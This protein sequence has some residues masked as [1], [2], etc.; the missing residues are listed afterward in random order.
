MSRT[1]NG[2]VQ[3][4]SAKTPRRSRPKL[5][6]ETLGNY[7]YELIRKQYQT[8]TKQEKRVLADRDPEGLH[9]MRVASRRL[10]T[11]LQVFERAIDLPKAA[12]SNR[13]QAIAK[14]LGNLR[15][16]DVQ[17]A[18]LNNEYLPLLPAAEQRSLEEVVQALQQER[19]K[20]FAATADILG[21]SRYRDLKDAYDTWLHQPR[22]TAL[23]NLP[24]MLV[25]PDLLNP[26]LSDLLLHPAWLIPLNQAAELSE[27]LHDLRKL[28]KH[29]RYQAEFFIDFY[30]PDFRA[31]VQEIRTIQEALGQLQDVQVLQE[32]L[33]E[34]LPKA[35]KL[36]KFQRLIQT[37]QNTALQEWEVLRPKYLLPDF[38]QQ[39]RQQL[40]NCQ[41]PAT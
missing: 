6:Q 31:W 39:L 21:R 29:V 1:S 8:L 3:A 40:L 26:L 32:L 16:L 34:H 2:K 27:T 41:A 28:C 4:T 11:A 10:R 35:V 20:A 17:L 12:N 37:R 13:I 19:R 14:V 30:G 18:D 24:L 5:P 38:R 33:A 36:P 25:I 15:D 23:A 9:D 22:Y 7:A